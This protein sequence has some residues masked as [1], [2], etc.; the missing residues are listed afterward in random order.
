MMLSTMKHFTDFN[1]F[2]CALSC[3]CKKKIIFNNIFLVIH[4]MFAFRFQLT[5][6]HVFTNAVNLHYLATKQGR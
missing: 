5:I 2:V 6:A 3:I 4:V 1:Y